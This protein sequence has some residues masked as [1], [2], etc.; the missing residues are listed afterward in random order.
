M[1]GARS[2]YFSRSLLAGFIFLNGMVNN[3]ANPPKATLVSR[4]LDLPTCY[5]LA[6]KRSERLA[7]TAEEIRHAK[8]RFRES[9]AAI[10]PKI[11]FFASA[12]FQNNPSG[13]SSSGGINDEGGGDN[14]NSGESRSG[15]RRERYETGIRLTQPI[16]A[17]FREFYASAAA[18]AN[19]EARGFDYARAKQI[20]FLDVADAFYQVLLYERDLKLLA[21]HQNILEDL[22]KELGRRLEIG[23]SRK[24]EV[25]EAQTE[26]ATLRVTIEQSR[27][28]L[29]SAK[30]LLG[31]L[32]GMPAEQIQVIE[33][34]AL[35]QQKEL[36]EYLAATGERPDLLSALASEQVATK[37]LSAARAERWPQI[38]L[39]ANYFPYDEPAQ[40]REWNVFITFDFPIF[41]GG[42]IE[43]RVEQQ[44]ARLRQ[45]MLTVEQ[46]RRTAAYEVRTAYHDL[47][48]SVAQTLQL[49]N[50]E[51]VATKNFDV[52]QKDYGLGVVS[53]LDVL[54]ARQNLQ[55]IR[56]QLLGTEIE[57]R[58]N[59]IR[60]NIA[61]GRF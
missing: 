3:Y 9:V 41:D 1:F 21:F 5:Q 12:R 11:N 28:V 26:L 46:L 19:I 15:G 36:A 23:R 57:G 58:I 20:L 14:L 31:F 61:A 7:I 51:E 60:L 43:A 55:E 56:R 44:K 38:A 6:L 30:E 39:E 25:L 47:N 34:Q 50:A 37:T 45:A 35:P 24:G 54:D 22:V 18:K 40:E 33:R 29:K 13:R 17:G 4:Q 42:A 2:F 27:G 53:N 59:L 8:A 10:L 16:F 32:I 49:R 48:T 52:Q